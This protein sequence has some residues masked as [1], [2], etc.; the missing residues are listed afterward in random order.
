MTNQGVFPD[1]CLS[2]DDLYRYL[3]VSGESGTFARL[4]AHLATCATCRQS[5]A[6]LIE[7]LHP[8]KDGSVAEIPDE[9]QLKRILRIVRDNSGGGPQSRNHFF[10][11]LRWPIA[12]A[13]VLC[14]VFL[15]SLGIE[16][17]Y[18][19]SRS[20]T[21]YA[22]AKEV[23]DQCYTGTSPSNLRLTLPFSPKSTDRV[24]RRDTLRPAENLLFQALAIRED[25]V[26]A[27]LGLAFIYLSESN[28]AR[29]ETEF[30]KVIEARQGH[31]Q[32]LVGR[33][34]ARF[35]AAVQST[36]PLRRIN[37]LKAALSD[38]D[39]ALRA[40]PASVEARYNKIWTLY[41]S[42]L[43]QDAQQEIERYLARDRDSTWAEKLKTLKARMEVLSS[44][45]LEE[46]IDQ[47]ARTRDRAALRELC[48]LVPYR[49]PAAIWSL[50]RRSLEPRDT[51]AE[52]PGAADLRWAAETLEP[53]YSEASGDG[54]FRNLIG[55]YV[56][57][58]P[59]QQ[60]LKRSLD[61][62]FQALVQ[63][64][65]KGQ[66]SPLLSQSKSLEAQYKVLQDQWQ[67]LNLY[68]LRGNS[69]YLGDADYYAAEAEFRKMHHMAQLL[70]APEPEAKALAGL[71]LILGQQRKFDE[72]LRTARRL[73]MLADKYQLLS[74]QIY[75]AVTIGNQYR[76][77]GQPQKA[78]EAYTAALRLA[79]RTSD[80]RNASEAYEYCG[81]VMD[82][83][84]R[85]K[86]AAALYALA[87]EHWDSLGGHT[88]TPD[89]ILRRLNLLLKQGDLALS[90]G[91]HSRAE[92]L[93]QE[94]LNS[95]EWEMPE[96]Q[97]RASIGLAEVYLAT[98]RNGA[99]ES[100]L[101]QALAVC[102]S[103]QYPDTEWKAKL[104]KGRLRE[105]QGRPADAL[106]MY[107]QS[108]D[109]LKRLRQN[110][111]DEELK[112]SLFSDRYDPF[113]SIA[114]LLFRSD[115]RKALEFVD[116]AKSA[117]LKEDLD[118]LLQNRE[119]STAAAGA[120]KTLEYFLTD[121][122][123]LIFVTD[124]D[125]V[126]SA[127]RA[128]S[129]EELSRQV[130][131]FLWCVKANDAVRFTHLSRLLYK[132]LIAPV[133]QVIFRE[134]METLVVLPDGPLHLLP[135]AGLKDNRDRFL[136]QKTALALAPSRSVFNH[137]LS[138]GRSDASRNR[139]V[140]LINGAEGLAHARD[141]LDYISQLYGRTASVH[142]GKDISKLEY[143]AKQTEILHFSGHAEMRQDGPVLV[144]RRFPE[145]IHLN[146]KTIRAW[147]LEK[148]RLVN[149]AGCATA[150]G[151]AAEGEAPWGLVPA[152]L[153]AGAPSIIAS[154]LPIDDEAT[155][156]LDLE[157]YALLKKGMSKARALQSAQLAL[158]KSSQALHHTGPRAWVPYILIGDPQ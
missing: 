122:G 71:A 130:Q 90:L 62:E 142:D 134:P 99:A 61:G 136:V 112:R 141:E 36:D 124:R 49:M 155:K 89:S 115:K 39:E 10:L 2:D 9:F 118:L 127:F 6:D 109:V 152:F 7:I 94:C 143:E 82:Q 64:H 54:S 100:L 114:A 137:C 56:G 16:F 101:D 102:Q 116:Q 156:K 149:L 35:E 150:I 38:F 84:G 95:T 15:S 98:K 14:L 3:T 96:L 132:E 125:R 11:R 47:A 69:L 1:S 24:I 37:L 86:E 87:A 131:D 48:R 108:I 73:Q 135:F 104:L 33:G 55:F 146:W 34:V 83:A 139:E 79:S 31:H 45:V 151:P 42:G 32:A 68:H 128:I 8:E 120:F 44:G 121:D 81:I 80:N 70:G 43:H 111:R 103:G 58:S 74:W 65:Q 77:L 13:A 126:E 19:R 63:L 85:L 117:T 25:M 113:K 92:A 26:E 75:A 4:E 40:E 29:A 5:L 46:R 59:P 93:F 12:A 110:I 21:F 157:F 105:H 144:L 97:A 147:R 17:F 20:R 66:F 72:S 60:E 91:E 140:L 27:H 50:M 106:N 52:G 57:L 23:I 158:L 123:L 67:L 30:Q 53:F 129:G 154:L 119:T 22:Q 145:E 88:N 133:E 18:E 153:N 107:H 41:E 138:L 76:W 78:L 51:S 148:A 28:F